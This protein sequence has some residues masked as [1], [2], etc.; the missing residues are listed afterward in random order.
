MY[1]EELEVVELEGSRAT[2]AASDHHKKDKK[3]R[4]SIEQGGHGGHSSPLKRRDSLS[5]KDK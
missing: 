3:H 4:K 5:K 2:G 1:G